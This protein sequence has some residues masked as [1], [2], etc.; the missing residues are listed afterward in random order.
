MRKRTGNIMGKRGL[1]LLL[2]L[3]MC[4]GMSTM[5]VH[6]ADP[7]KHPEELRTYTVNEENSLQHDWACSC[8]YEE[9]WDEH[10]LDDNGQCVYC[11]QVV[12]KLFVSGIPVSTENAQDVLGDGGSVRYDEATNTL[13]LNNATIQ[14]SK[15]VRGT[16]IYAIGKDTL[17]LQLE[18]ANT[19]TGV[20]SDDKH[21]DAGVYVDGKLQVQ[22][23]GSLTSTTTVDGSEERRTIPDLSAGIFAR[24]GFTMLS[25][26]LH[27]IGGEAHDISVGIYSFNGDAFEL[28]DSYN[29][30]ISILGGTV[31]LEGGPIRSPYGGNILFS[32]VSSAAAVGALDLSGYPY[33]AWT[34]DKNQEAKEIP[35]SVT[36][37]EINY[38]HVDAGDHQIT[39]QPILNNRYEIEAQEYEEGQW[40]QITDDISYQWYEYITKTVG[41]DPSAKELLGASY[42]GM[43][44]YEDGYWKSFH[45]EGDTGLY[46]DV[47]AIMFPVE[48]GNQISVNLKEDVEGTF[49]LMGPDRE[50]K[51]IYPGCH[52][53]VEDK[54]IYSYDESVYGPIFAGLTDGADYAFFVALTMEPFEAEI[55][56]YSSVPVETMAETPN[57]FQY[58]GEGSYFGRATVEDPSGILAVLD[59]EIFEYLPIYTVTY[60]AGEGACST[61]FQDTVPGTGML[62][63]ECIMPVATRENYVFRGWAT[64]NGDTVTTETVF[65][66]NVT[67]YAVWDVKVTDVPEACTELVYDGSE[68]TLIQEGTGTA[69]STMMYSLSEDGPYETSLPAA[70]KAGTYTVWY[71]AAAQEGSGHGDSEIG[72]L[73]AKIHKAVPEVELPVGLQAVYGQTLS[74]VALPEVQNGTWAWAQGDAIVGDAGLQTHRIVF[75]P[76]DTDNYEPLTEQVTV[77]VERAEVTVV[78]A[79][80]QAP[81]YGDTPDTIENGEYYTA[82]IQWNPETETFGYN[83]QYTVV[84]TLTP[85]DNHVFA[86]EI[87]IKDDSNTDI[88]DRYDIQQNDD[89]TLTLTRTFAATRKEKL[90]GISKPED[91]H[92]TA[93][94][95]DVAEAI[96]QLPSKV[97]YTTENNCTITVD[98]TWTCEDYDPAVQK[99][100]SFTWTV[101]KE[102]DLAEYDRNGM[103][104]SGSIQVT[105]ADPLEVN[106]EGNESE[107]TYSSHP[108]DVSQLFVI[109]ETTATAV[110][111]LVAEEDDM[112]GHGIL[113]NGMLTITK[114]GVFIIKMKTAANGA[115]A[116]GEA[117]AI[118]RV[119][120]AN[121]VAT[122]SMKNWTYLDEA[123]E[124]QLVSITNG[125]DHVSYLYE[126]TDG[127]GY[128]G[129]AVPQ[130]AGSYKV[131]ATF[132]ENDLYKACIV[133]AEFIIAPKNIQGA[134]VSLDPQKLTYTGQEQEQKVLGVTLGDVTV[135]EYTISG[136]KNTEPGIYE[137]TITASGDFRG[138]VTAKYMIYPDLSQDTVTS[139]DA[140]DL[141]QLVKEIDSLLFNSSLTED[142]KKVLTDA[143]AE[144]EALLDQIDKTQEKL[145]EI[146]SALDG[147]NEENV[148]SADEENLNQVVKD[149]EDLLTGE[150][151]TED[152]KKDLAEIKAEAEGLLD[153][154]A[155]KT[156][157]E[158]MEQL[159]DTVKP[160]DNETGK[161][162]QAAKDAYDQ[163]SDHGKTLVDINVSKKLQK[164]FAELTDYQLLE[165]SG[166]IWVKGSKD[167]IRF[168]ANGSHEKVSGIKVDG[169]VVDLTNYTIQ[170]GSTIILFKTEYLETLQVGEHSFE[171]VYT[172]GEVK[173]SFTIQS[174][175]KP[176]EPDTPEQSDQPSASERPST[177]EQ[178]NTSE[179]PLTGD[180]SGVE[181]WIT[182]C[183][184][185]AAAIMALFVME[186]KKQIR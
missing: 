136:H 99:T 185:S 168:K 97:E 37:M 108:V 173:G 20:H 152:E 14:G 174:D 166:D 77:M 112:A 113:N 1:S 81:A 109:D 2:A 106:H 160:D 143:K 26:S 7:C 186:Q 148:T 167:G 134:Q 16:G 45:V 40:S 176:V 66:Q 125:V 119:K 183:M 52:W 141:E 73:T 149:M 107:I 90:D 76:Q 69:G 163:L 64:E 18:G 130:H 98:I 132:G 153:V 11:Y 55:K 72:S 111:E 137:L 142:E 179:A 43:N 58:G 115:Y 124:P 157:T 138:A 24:R 88:T 103:A 151:L 86:E 8:G 78:I 180:L 89:G 70:V 82:Q 104:I 156:F 161:L 92:L 159:P 139:A 36:G 6:A 48:E 91:Q 135:E 80:I 172:D 15:E 102:V 27:A 21:V 42:G 50:G 54:W 116:S 110:Y 61:A 47:M 44:T 122:M 74:Q 3:T 131:T 9:E 95:E 84:L 94:S 126:S 56:V 120:K 177:S 29:S 65:D 17:V 133:E 96:A 60:D 150:N 118:L 147:L 158:Q 144:A 46:I 71:Y 62:G 85:D 19:V 30:L 33:A 129:T 83:T 123:A 175:E 51:F 100:N 140:E 34:A 12:P 23:E 38:L 178:L 79:D 75:T 155:V 32:S 57:R 105:N 128:V 59:T 184:F 165:G 22:G 28:I 146:Q 87:Q 41:S 13:T 127:K 182:M 164:L 31:T 101:S 53:T 5:P 10:V 114:T 39:A 49:F 181:G 63:S 93:Y 169:K 154:L 121:G 68:K 35:L 25:G 67:V 171:L 170:K 117:T 162:I 4:F 145:E